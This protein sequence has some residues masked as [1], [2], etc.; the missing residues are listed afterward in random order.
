VTELFWMLFVLALAV[1]ILMSIAALRH[2]RSSSHYVGLRWRLITGT[3]ALVAA[4]A[5]VF[6]GVQAYKQGVTEAAQEQRYEQQVHR[7]IQPVAAELERLEFTA[8]AHRTLDDLS[9]YSFDSP[10]HRSGRVS[11][12]GDK[13]QPIMVQF[14][15]TD[16]GVYV[17]CN[18]RDDFLPV[19]P[20]GAKLLRA[21]S[22]GC[23]G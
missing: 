16:E 8:V 14:R 3:T 12:L 22:R 5:A 10:D 11:L 23:A 19:T 7:Q 13:E 1:A 6:C 18:T 2:L 20:Y 17:G 15:V 4:L 9:L 21:T